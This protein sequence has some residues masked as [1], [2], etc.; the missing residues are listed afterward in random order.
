M[1]CGRDEEFAMMQIIGNIWR[2]HH[3]DVFNVPGY[4]RLSGGKRCAFKYREFH[5][6]I[7]IH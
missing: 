1:V 3:I 7:D 2:I 4:A 6:V 5:H